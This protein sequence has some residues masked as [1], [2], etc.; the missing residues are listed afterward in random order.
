MR[1]ILGLSLMG[2]GAGITAAPKAVDSDTDSESDTDTDADADAD[3]DTDA[4]T[5]SDTDTD[6]EWSH[7]ITIDGDPGEWTQDEAF[8]TTGGTT[9]ITWDAT[10]L[11]VG[12]DHPDVATGSSDHW[13]LIYV[14]NGGG[15]ASGVTFNTQQPAISAPMSHLVRWKADDSYSSLMSWSGQAWVDNPGLLGTGGS[16][17]EEGIAVEFAIPFSMLGVSDTFDVHVNWLYE[18]TGFESTYSPTPDGSHSDE[19]DPDY[20]QTLLFDR[21]ESQAPTAYSAVP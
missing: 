18:G 8:A 19:Y 16:D 10:T 21:R 15:E 12:I 9:W 6:T 1:W 7:T 5:D 13:V 14:G 17:W 2:C 4:D 20:S 3:A 11:Y